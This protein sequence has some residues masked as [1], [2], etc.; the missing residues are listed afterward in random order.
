MEDPSPQAAPG[1]DGFVR[2]LGL[3]DATMIVAGSMIGSGIFIVSADIARQV[4]SPGLLL[5][6]WAI[7]GLLT[8][9][10][11]LA[12]GELAA[13]MP[14]VGGQYVY[15]REAYSPL[16]GFL[17]GWALILV[18]QTGTIAAVAVAFARFLGVLVPAVSPA[19]WIVPPI[20][21][22]EGYALSLSLQQLVAIL[23]VVVL[24][25]IN[26]RGLRL[27]ALIQNSFTLTKTAALIG[28]ILVGL[29]L[30]WNAGAVE[31]NFTDF[32]APRAPAPAAGGLAALVVALAAAQVGSYFACDAW[33][34]VAFAS[35]EVRDAPRTL[36]RAMAQG[37]ALVIGLYLL[38]NLAYLVT[39]PLEAIQSAPD[40][41][42]GTAALAAI[43]GGPGAVIMACLI[44]V[45]TFG[46]N[47]GLILA[48]A[49]VY[50]AMARD[51]LFFRSAGTLN[52]ARVPGTALLLQ[53]VVT[54]LLILPRTRTPG[55]GYGNLYSNLLD[56]VV[57]SVLL[58]S[59]LTIAGLF[60]LRR[61][62]PD[63]ERPYRA[64]GYPVVPA[65]ALA[66]AAAIAGVLA[67]TKARTTWPGLVIVLSG[68][69]VYALWRAAARSASRRTNASY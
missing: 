43:F 27:G 56:Y 5:V 29:V 17:Y 69:P 25:A 15:L 35:A 64:W 16:F 9:A 54:S 39:L 33:H 30:G 11:A 50:Y 32:W 24:T 28:L 41:R 12:Y 67:V 34:N 61:R 59:V 57:V 20:H 58:F 44:L 31:A 51:G 1:D 45:S 46:C 23:M 66:G 38:A 10:G 3:L 65:L 21:L 19:W 14:R 8:V 42:V 68:I 47:N 18:I 63:A 26:M 13:M 62:R 40:D 6:T 55:G 48:G 36:P 49:R 4:G 52:A 22:S 37:A 60:V 2:G 53:C 7:T